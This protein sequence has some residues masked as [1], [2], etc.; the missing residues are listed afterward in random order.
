MSPRRIAVAAGVVLV[1]GAVAAVLLHGHEDKHPVAAL[2]ITWG[3]SEG[4][5]SCH[6]DA[7]S[8]TVAARLAISGRAARSGTATVKVTAYADENTSVPVGSA[9]RNVHVGGLMHKNVIVTIPVSSPPQVGEDDVTA[10]KLAVKY[11][12]G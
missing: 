8:R 11:P 4:V 12:H 7:A 9:S 6:Y 2:T 3:G 1:L 10:C 5:S